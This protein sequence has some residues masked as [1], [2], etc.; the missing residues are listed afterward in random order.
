MH[1]FDLYRKACA[2]CYNIM[3]QLGLKQPKTTYIVVRTDP[4]G[5]KNGE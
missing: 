5:M 2:S 4:P 1:V 3:F